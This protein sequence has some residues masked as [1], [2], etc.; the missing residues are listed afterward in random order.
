MSLQPASSRSAHGS[1]A[2]VRPIEA[3]TFSSIPVAKK[4][5]MVA[6]RAGTR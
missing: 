1:A 6:G 4:A 2:A 5:E 3:K